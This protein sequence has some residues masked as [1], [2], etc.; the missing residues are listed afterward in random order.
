MNKIYSGLY[1][2]LKYIIMSKILI[3][4]GDESFG[5][6]FAKDYGT[7]DQVRFLFPLKGLEYFVESLMALTDEYDFVIN[8]FDMPFYSKTSQNIEMNFR[9]QEIINEKFHH[10]KKILLSNQLVYSSSELP[11][12]E[13]YE[14]VPETQYGK[15]QLKAEQS[16]KQNDHFLIIR[17]G[18]TY[19]KCTYN[20]YT[21]ILTATRGNMPL[22]LNNDIKV[23]P[24]LNSDLSSG[25]N[26]TMRSTDRE[27]INMAGEEVMTLYEFGSVLYSSIHD[28]PCPFIKTYNGKNLNYNMDVSR[29][30]NDFG[31][32]F[33]V[34]EGIDFINF[35]T[36]KNE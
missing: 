27:I 2:W 30:R 12:N 31:L 33:N 25:V 6:R 35:H 26:K 4:D 16:V 29:A 3:I 5:F 10:G 17:R 21:D 19:G 9:I 28:G 24:V 34:L 36:G 22:K 20:I 23:N 8:N 15:T 13:G 14:T 1:G 11:K 7:T 32:N 18:M